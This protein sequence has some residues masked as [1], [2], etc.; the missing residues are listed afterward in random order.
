MPLAWYQFGETEMAKRNAM[1]KRNKVEMFEVVLTDAVTAMYRVLGL[2]KD[3]AVSV[4][5]L[6]K[7][8]DAAGLLEDAIVT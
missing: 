2:R 6:R 8:L 5:E 1:G 3:K 7:R 4:D